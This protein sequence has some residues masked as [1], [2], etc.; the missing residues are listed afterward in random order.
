MGII[1]SVTS[2]DFVTQHFRHSSDPVIFFLKEKEIDKIKRPG[3]QNRYEMI[4]NLV[5]LFTL[6]AL[7]FASTGQ[8]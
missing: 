1:M 2:L 6:E 5:H 8:S 7:Q 3:F 4:K